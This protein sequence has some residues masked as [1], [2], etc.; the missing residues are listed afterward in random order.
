MPLVQ[1]K[2][3]SAGA[4]ARYNETNVCYFER[5]ACSR[6]MTVAVYDRMLARLRGNVTEV[7]RPR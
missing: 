3:A 7:V 1:D 6:G 2:V 4:M 5:M